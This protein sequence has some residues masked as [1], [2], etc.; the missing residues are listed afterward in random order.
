LRLRLRLIAIN[1][2][3]AP[4][5]TDIKIQNQILSIIYSDFKF[6]KIIG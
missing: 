2:A 4:M 6:K 3:I 5:T 1:P